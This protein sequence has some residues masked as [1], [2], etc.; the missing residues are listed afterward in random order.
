MKQNK[1]SQTKFNYKLTVAYDGT[2]F[3]GFQIQ[4][5]GLKTIQSELER[6]LTDMVFGKEKNENKVNPSTNKITVVASGRTDAGV[7]AKAQVCNFI[8]PAFIPPSGVMKTLNA[9]LPATIRAVKCEAVDESFSARFSAKIKTYSYTI[10]NGDVLSPFDVRFCLHIKKELDINLMKNAAKVLIGK[11]NFEGFCKANSEVKDFVR[12]VLKIEIKEESK[13]NG[14]IIKVFVTGNGFLHNM[15][16]IIAGAL[17]GAA[18]GSLSPS[19]IKDILE[20]GK[21][22]PKIITMPPH[23]LCLEEVIY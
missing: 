15:V 9:F 2:D 19:E 22:T 13:E 17:I 11:H 6:V 5:G 21:R 16:R 1:T 4:N 8:L 12:E 14:K 3:A 7:H 23:G 10:F 20:S 18:N